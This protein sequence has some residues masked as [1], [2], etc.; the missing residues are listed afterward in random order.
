MKTSI[1]GF[2]TAITFVALMFYGCTKT[3]E[4]NNGSLPESDLTTVGSHAYGLLPMTPDQ[5]LNIPLYSKEAF[6]AGKTLKATTVKV[7]IYTLA[8][9]AVRNQGSIGSCTAFC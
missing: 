4:L 9:P 3:N 7:P 2:L 8:T 1:S 6:E 5:Y